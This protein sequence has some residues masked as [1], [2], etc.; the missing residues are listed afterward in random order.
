MPVNCERPAPTALSLR[1]FLSSLFLCSFLAFIPLS[2]SRDIYIA[3]P[4]PAD[5]AAVP[6]LFLRT[7]YLRDA[8]RAFMFLSVTVPLCSFPSCPFSSCSVSCLLP[9]SLF[10]PATV[11]A[12]SSS[13]RVVYYQS[14]F[15]SI[16]FFSFDCCYRFFSFLFQQPSAAAFSLSSSLF[17]FHSFFIEITPSFVFGQSFSGSFFFYFAGVLSHVHARMS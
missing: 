16:D 9:C 13:V 3:R 7:T 1:F 11:C 8:S 2:V 5:S 15:A 12:N 4:G 6:A 10:H 17:L 14:E